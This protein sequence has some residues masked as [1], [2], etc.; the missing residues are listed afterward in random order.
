MTKI[1]INN[2]RHYAG[3]R[4]GNTQLNPYQTFA[5]MLLRGE[6]VLTST[7]AFVNHLIT[8]RPT[9]FGSLFGD[10]RLDGKP[11][12]LYPWSGPGGRDESSGL[13]SGWLESPEDVPDVMTH[14]SPA[15]IP[16]EMIESESQWSSNTVTSIRLHGYQPKAFSP[17][18][19]VRIARNRDE[20]YIVVDGNHRLSALA[21]L[22]VTH[23]RVQVVKSF[24]VSRPKTLPGVRSGAYSPGEVDVLFYHY[25]IG[26]NVRCPD[27]ASR[28]VG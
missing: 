7:G 14:F 13:P 12:W 20:F 8:F 25:L 27:E 3:Y 28:V 16:R 2:L 18:Q 15:G 5:D 4:Y 24:D 1:D 9:C 23:A 6:S 10:R 11:L 21:A 17:I 26:L 19:A 22:Q